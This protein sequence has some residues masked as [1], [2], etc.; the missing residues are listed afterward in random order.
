MSFSRRTGLAPP[1][2]ALLGDISSRTRIGLWN[3]VHK[4]VTKKRKVD[5]VL[6]SIFDDHLRIPRQG[7]RDYEEALA[8]LGHWFEASASWN[9]TFDL[10]EFL[11]AQRISEFSL[12]QDCNKVLEG[13]NSGYR[14]VDLRLVPLSAPGETEAVTGA[15]DAAT[16][17][18]MT[19]VRLHLEKA[20][21][22][23]AQRPTPDA[24]NAIKEAISAVEAIAWIIAGRKTNKF[25]DALK[26]FDATGVKLHPALRNAL[27][28]FFG[29]TS[30]RSGV[31]HAHGPGTTEADVAD[32]AEARLMV[33]TCSAITT[34]LIELHRRSKTPNG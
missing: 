11:L 29:Y 16:G 18:E 7:V 17:D 24:S 4:W 32:L 13:E 12:A 28:V 9:E 25:V 19:P 33:H 31:R 26:E 22:M 5:D 6:D 14:I 2:H 8:R 3:V 20:I 23:L 27:S 21:S 34:Y 1:T 30:D 15:L 10:I